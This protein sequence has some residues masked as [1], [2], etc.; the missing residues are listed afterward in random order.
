MKLFR[1]HIVLIPLIS[2]GGSSFVGLSLQPPGCPQHPIFKY[3]L[4][5]L[6]NVMGKIYEEIEI[7]GR[8][9][10]VK[11]D[12]ASD[13]A[14]CLRRETIDELKLPLSPRKAQT[15]REENGETIKVREDVWV[16]RI[17]I[18][19]CEFA[20]PQFVIEA[21]GENLLGNPILQALGAKIDEKN[22]TVDFDSDM[23]PRGDTGEVMGTLCTE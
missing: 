10:K 15:S 12:T 1:R 9:V 2:T 21:H 16:A 13:F 18:R 6:I 17:K 22:E 14:L 4:R 7:E 19:G 8:P 20:A 11:I 5:L 23:C 3:P